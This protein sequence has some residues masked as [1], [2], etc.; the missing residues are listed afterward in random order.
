M[1]TLCCEATLQPLERFNLDAAILFSDI[2]NIV[3][4]FGFDLKYEKNIGPVIN[5]KDLSES[6]IVA[7]NNEK[8]INNLEYVFNNIRL[9]KKE[10]KNKPLIGFAGSPWTVSCYIVEGYSTKKFNI[11]RSMLYKDP[12]MLHALLKKIAHCTFLY[13]EKQIEAGCDVIKIFDSWGGI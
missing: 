5:N 8:A 1:G 9:I 4:A 6:K 11:I 12:Q 13:L 10:L 3:E 2:L 7:L